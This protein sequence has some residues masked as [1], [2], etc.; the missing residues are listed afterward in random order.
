MTDT[1]SASTTR[2]PETEKMFIGTAHERL[3]TPGCDMVVLLAA[4]IGGGPAQVLL[5][6]TN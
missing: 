3:R 2:D 5:R 6:L 4:P 1:T